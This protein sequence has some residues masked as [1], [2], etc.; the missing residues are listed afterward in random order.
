MKIKLINNEDGYDV[1]SN[2][3][4][5]HADENF[6]D[7]YRCEFLAFIKL[8]DDSQWITKE[9]F[10]HNGDD[11]MW[12]TDWWEGQEEFELLGYTCVEDIEEPE[13]KL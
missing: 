12:D 1:V 5:K 3:I 4:R 13:V 8:Y 7:Y 2:I 6:T 11:V 9:F 10:T